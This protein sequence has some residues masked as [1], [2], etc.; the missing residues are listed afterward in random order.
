VLILGF[1]AQTNGNIVV[2]NYVCSSKI[3]LCCPTVSQWLTIS[4][5]KPRVYGALVAA[6]TTQVRFKCGYI[7]TTQSRRAG[8][9]LGSL[10]QRRKPEQNTR[11]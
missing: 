7:M 4:G 10:S 3:H 11:R 2:N 1:L 6:Y 9:K 5:S 8:R